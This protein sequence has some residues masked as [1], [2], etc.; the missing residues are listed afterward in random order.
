MRKKF[1]IQDS[2][3]KNTFQSSILNLNLL[4]QSEKEIEE[5]FDLIYILQE[6]K[7]ELS[8]QFSKDYHPAVK[9]LV[10]VVLERI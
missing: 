5:A 6:K 3:F 1:K 4:F 9:K 10:E 2:R 7:I 8:E